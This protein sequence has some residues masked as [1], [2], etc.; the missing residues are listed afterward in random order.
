MSRQLQVALDQF[1]SSQRRA[2]ALQGELDEV[3]NGL[4][5]VSL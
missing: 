5:A 3:R 1:S 2:Q 4:E